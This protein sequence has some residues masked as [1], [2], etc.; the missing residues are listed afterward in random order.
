MPE[1][2]STLQPF[3]VPGLGSQND[4][5]IA[6]NGIIRAPQYFLDLGTCWAPGKELGV[7]QGGGSPPCG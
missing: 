5:T 3:V 4:A 1:L 6:L 2:L 7:G